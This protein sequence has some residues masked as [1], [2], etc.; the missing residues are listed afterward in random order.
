MHKTFFYLFCW[1]FFIF[2]LLFLRHEIFKKMYLEMHE[3]SLLFFLRRYEFFFLKNV[4]I[5]KIFYL[6]STFFKTEMYKCHKSAWTYAWNLFENSWETNECMMKINICHFCLL[7]AWCIHEMYFYRMNNNIKMH[8]CMRLWRC[9]DEC[10]R[11]ICN[12]FFLRIHLCYLHG[13]TWIVDETLDE[14]EYM[15]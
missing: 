8:E 1:I 2:I 14:N 13:S 7:N 12:Y 15:I 3:I 5:T 6:M 4:W 9:M 10:T 11:S